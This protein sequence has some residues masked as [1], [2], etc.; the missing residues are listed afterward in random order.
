MGVFRSSSCLMIWSKLGTGLFGSELFGRSLV[1]S[2]GKFAVFGV[3]S[4]G[5]TGLGDC[6]DFA[7]H[8]ESALEGGLSGDESAEESEDDESTE[9]GGDVTVTKLGGS[10]LDGPDVIGS[11]DELD[12]VGEAARFEE[13]GVMAA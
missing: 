3:C 6:G 7:E 13:V 1:I 8:G 11:S 10:M 2:E 9:D 4:L 5:R 12:G